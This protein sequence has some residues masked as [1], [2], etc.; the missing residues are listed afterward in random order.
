[1]EQAS[2]PAEGTPKLSFF[3]RLRIALFLLFGAFAMI[4]VLFAALVVLVLVA[5]LA[6]TGKGL[7]V[8]VKLAKVIWIALLPAWAVIKMGWRTLSFREPPVQ[9]RR[10]Q[11]EDAPML[12]TALDDMRRTLRGPKVAE[13]V[14]SN[15]LN[16]YAITRPLGGYWFIP[17]R[18][19]I[20]SL[21]VPLLQSLSAD[22]MLAV[23][24]HEY[25]HLS[26]HPSRFDAFVYRCRWHF[27]Q[28]LQQT[29]NWQ[30]WAS[31][32][33]AGFLNWY[34]RKFDRLSFALCRDSEYAADAISAHYAGK[35][36]AAAALARVNVASGYINGHGFWAPIYARTETEAEPTVRPWSQLPALVRPRHDQNVS[37]DLLRSALDTETGTH[38]THPA[39]ADR[40]AALGVDAEAFRDHR[41]EIRPVAESSAAEA[42]F[43]A[44]LAR[45]LE[46]FDREWQDRVR[47]DWRRR[48]EEQRAQQERKS[49]LAAARDEALK[50]ARALDAD[51]AWGLLEMRLDANE[52]EDPDRELLDF[53]AA[54]PGHAQ[55]RLV[56]GR[57][58]LDQDEARAA[59]ALR[60]A[61]LLDPAC[62]GDAALA[63]ARH[64]GGKDDADERAKSARYALMWRRYAQGGTA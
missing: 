47:D 63:L 56:W 32:K 38:D 26:G 37:A 23:V 9:G 8:L 19:R 27:L 54:Y 7:I 20:I 58:N 45:L 39:L 22:E 17:L 64:Y 3:Y 2:P 46:P 53:I 55:S 52:C 16:A 33:F 1:M 28:M 11:R 60:E 59:A 5:A 30:D 49:A 10:L 44:N 40:L 50:N 57:A 29:A 4:V 24:A 13:V 43:G 35:D 51:T 36:I 6:L 61:V 34:I 21:G 48:H 14:L 25:G 62:A 18:R 42:W 15:E 41:I 31:R 12:F